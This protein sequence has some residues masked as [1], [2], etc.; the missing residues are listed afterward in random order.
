MYDSQVNCLGYET[1][2]ELDNL[3]IKVIVD[4]ETDPLSSSSTGLGIVSNEIQRSITNKNNELNISEF[5]CSAHGFSILLTGTLDGEEHT[6]LFDAGPYGEIF[7]DNARKLGIEYEKIE[8]VVLSHWHCDHSGGL[9]DAISKISEARLQN[10]NPPIIDL[11]LDRPS[12][13]GIKS[14]SNGHIMIMNNPTFEELEN[15][16]GQ[17]LKSNTPHT[18]CSNFFFI[19]GEINRQ[20]TYETGIPNHMRYNELTQ[21]WEEDPLI[22][23]ERFMVVRIKGKGLIV[24]T[25]CGHAGIVNTSLQAQQPVNS[26]DIKKQEIEKFSILLLFGGFHLS[27]R[28]LEIRIKETVR[29]LK[30]LINPAY[31]APGHCSGWRCRAALEWDPINENDDEKV[32]KAGGFFT[33]RV[34]TSSVGKIFNINGI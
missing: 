6:V 32:S 7:L 19:S 14:P 18:I 15:A 5:C 17:I 20:T 9:V 34:V 23:E 8:A 16:G 13:R 2:K 1:L 27:G 4:N 21:S 25:G 33:G 29:D 28:D 11:P 24:I 3:I 12:R 26:Q 10:F 31:L 30:N 22:M